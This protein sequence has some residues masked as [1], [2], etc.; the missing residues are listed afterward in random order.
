MQMFIAGASIINNNKWLITS[1]GG[2]VISIYDINS[3]CLIME[4]NLKMANEEFNE[5]LYFEPTYFSPDGT[6]VLGYIDGDGGTNYFVR[7]NIPS[8]Y[9]YINHARS[10]FKRFWASTPNKDI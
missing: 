10:E 1:S 2:G 8:V 9:D 7:C 6:Y 5:H 3:G 4:Y